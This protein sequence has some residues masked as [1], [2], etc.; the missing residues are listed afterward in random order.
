MR[1]KCRQVYGAH[2]R[3]LEELEAELA[4]ATD[5]L[6]VSRLEASAAG[7]RLTFEAR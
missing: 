3:R 4:R 1:E 2:A 7:F 5:A 6:E